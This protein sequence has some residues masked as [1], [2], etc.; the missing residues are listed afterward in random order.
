VGRFGKPDFTGKNHLFLTQTR[1]PS[2][3]FS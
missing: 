3:H 1:R 2:L